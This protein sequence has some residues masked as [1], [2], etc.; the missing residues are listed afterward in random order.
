MNDTDNVSTD[1]FT[2]DDVAVHPRP[3][4]M[5]RA[6]L[7]M[8][9]RGVGFGRGAEPRGDA[10]RSVR[11]AMGSGWTESVSPTWCDGRCVAAASVGSGA[12]GTRSSSDR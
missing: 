12:G 5:R 9:M 8:L 11:R 10:G 3:I 7:G 4:D 1:Q 6:V 2:A